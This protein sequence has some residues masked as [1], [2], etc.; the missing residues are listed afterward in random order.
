MQPPRF[1]R[2]QL[3]RLHCAPS[4]HARLANDLATFERDRLCKLFLPALDLLRR[5][6][7]NLI[8]LVRRQLRH[9][10]R[11]AHRRRQRLVHVAGITVRHGIH[12]R[13]VEW[14]R[15]V[16]GKEGVS[17]CPETAVCFDCLEQLQ[18]S[19]QVKPEEEVV[20]FNTGAA[21]KYPE[22]VPLDLPRIDKNM[23]VDY[24][25]LARR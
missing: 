9:H 6:H 11:A 14:M 5:L 2:R 21:Q 24:E 4:L 15:R 16:I 18:A 3:Q 22:V 23:P 7:Q 1:L 25:A 13:I 17:I 12:E 8:T 20:V 10:L 19:G